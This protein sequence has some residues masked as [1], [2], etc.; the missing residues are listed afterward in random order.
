MTPI[1][2]KDTRSKKQ[3]QADANA[4][5]MTRAM[6]AQFLKTAISNI[7]ADGDSPQPKTQPLQPTFW[8]LDTKARM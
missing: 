7:I 3:R 2:I 8:T 5:A 1:I 4:V 6:A